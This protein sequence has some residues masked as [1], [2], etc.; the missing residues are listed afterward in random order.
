MVC[1]DLSF[2][3]FLCMFC[4]Y[5]CHAVNEIS[6]VWQQ[7]STPWAIKRSQVIFVCNFVKNQRILMQFSLIDLEMNGTCES[8]NFTH[9]T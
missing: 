4:R 5:V 6:E 1:G 9:F 3:F 7:L 8:M 2:T